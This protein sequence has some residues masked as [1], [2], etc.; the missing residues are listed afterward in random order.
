MTLLDLSRDHT[1][2]SKLRHEIATLGDGEFDF[3]AV[4]KL[5]YL[6]AVVREG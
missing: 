3:D 6:D 4:Q 5:E 2:Q 1:S